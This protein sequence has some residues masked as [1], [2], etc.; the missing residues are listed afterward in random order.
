MISEAE[1]EVEDPKVPLPAVFPA[2][3]IGVYPALQESEVTV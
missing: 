1:D 3:L 2:R